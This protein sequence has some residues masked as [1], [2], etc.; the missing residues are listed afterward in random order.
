MDI[1]GRFF[2]FP[3]P[4]VGLWEMNEYIGVD[5]G[6]RLDGPS[7]C[8]IRMDRAGND[9]TGQTTLRLSPVAW[10]DVQINISWLP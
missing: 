4:V 3:P 2:D 5:S 1:S 8:G 7:L 9:R 10:L 6:V